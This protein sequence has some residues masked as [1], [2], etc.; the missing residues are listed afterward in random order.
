MSET[1]NNLLEK[2]TRDL[3]R[4]I[5]EYKDKIRQDIGGEC[6]SKA[7]SLYD[8]RG[9]GGLWW[10]GDLSQIGLDFGLHHTYFV[11]EKSNEDD[12]ALN[13]ADNGF[14]QYPPLTVKE[15]TSLG[16]LQETDIIRELVSHQ[17]K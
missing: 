17:E 16:K 1:L 11:P 7:L 10:I 4:K 13:Q 3:A 2:Q 15:V 9:G 14:A 6:L 8:S 5:L 12:Q